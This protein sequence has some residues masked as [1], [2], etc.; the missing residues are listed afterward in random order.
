LKSIEKYENGL[1]V[2]IERYNEKGQL[3]TEENYKNGKKH[4]L[5]QRYNEAGEL[6]ETADYENGRLIRRTRLTDQGKE[7]ITTEGDLQK[8]EKFDAAGRIRYMGF[9]RL[10]TGRPDSLEVYY[11]PATGYKEKEILYRNGQPVYEGRFRDGVKHGKWKYYL[12]GGKGVKIVE[13]DNGSRVSENEVLFDRQIK[14]LVKDGDYV[15]EQT[16]FYPEI[17][18]EYYLIHVPVV[19]DKERRYILDRFFEVLNRNAM[20]KVEDTTGIGDYQVDGILSIDSLAT[21][22]RTKDKRYLYLIYTRLHFKRFPGMEKKLDRMIF[23][24]HP[25]G[26]LMRSYVKDKKDAYFK[27]L[28]AFGKE[29]KSFVQ[30]HMPLKIAARPVGASRN[31]VESLALN[32]GANA[33]LRPKM[34]LTAT[35]QTEKGP[36]E[37]VVVVEQVSDKLARADVFKGRLSLRKYFQNHK[38][39]MLKPKE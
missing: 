38:L 28:D 7:I 34:L 32:A 14:N 3:I 8:T 15:F 21:R 4:G 39:I 2:H 19:H 18:K 26:E 9:V 36:E 25:S 10:S 20:R 27:S 16:Q 12:P 31:Y 17:H 23:Y 33:G 13:Y 5:Q 37:I 1:P 29:M 24:K 11:N 6:T 22:L 30:K 35:V